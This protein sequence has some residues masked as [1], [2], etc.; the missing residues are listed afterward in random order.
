[1]ETCSFEPSP[2]PSQPIFAINWAPLLVSR[3]RGFGGTLNEID[4]LGA[5]QNRSKRKMGI[6]KEVF[7]TMLVVLQKKLGVVRE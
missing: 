1:M 3:S 4:V 6:F 7:F 2:L 5:L